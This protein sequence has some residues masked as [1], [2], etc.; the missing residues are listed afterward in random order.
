MAI[1]QV[2]T[3]QQLLR[4]QSE[5]PISER[6]NTILLKFREAVPH[7]RTAEFYRIHLTRQ[8]AADGEGEFYRPEVFQPGQSH[9]TKVCLR[10]R[11][12]MG[13]INQCD[14]KCQ[15]SR[16]D[17]YRRVVQSGPKRG[18]VNVQI[19]PSW[20]VEEV[21]RPSPI[22]RPHG[23]VITHSRTGVLLTSKV[24]MVRQCQVVLDRRY[25]ERT[26]AAVYRT[27]CQVAETMGMIVL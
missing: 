20:I 25:D 3:N 14:W 16:C 23:E 17:N 5:L 6:Q 24:V 9:S 1:E 27:A 12:P 18:V 15:N 4:F 26:L 19:H 8:M 22:R 13:R 11:L 7:S 10:C 21:V 2:V